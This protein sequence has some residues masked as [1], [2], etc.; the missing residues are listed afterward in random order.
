[1]TP[2]SCGSVVTTLFVPPAPDSGDPSRGSRRVGNSI[3]ITAATRRIE[4]PSAT[5]LT[6]TPGQVG[7]TEIRTAAPAITS[8]PRTR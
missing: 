3:P 6:T 5:A 8:A 4:M 2:G 1:M 7:H